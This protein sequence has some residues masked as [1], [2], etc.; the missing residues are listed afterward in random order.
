MHTYEL[1]P[2][3]LQADLGD[4]DPFLCSDMDQATAEKVQLSRSF[5]KKFMDVKGE[6]ADD[7]ALSEFFHNNERCKHYRFDSDCSF[8][9]MVREEVKSL[10]DDMFHCGPDLTMTPSVIYGGIGVGPGASIG[11]DAF[12]FYTKT[13]ASTLSGTSEELYRHYRYAIA[14][15]PTWLAGEKSRLAKFGNALVA[16][17]RLSTVPK[18]VDKSRTICTEPVLNMFLQKGIGAFFERLLIKHFGINLSTQPELNK[19]LAR[20]GS[21]DGSFGTI[22]LSCASDSISLGLV[23][24]LFPAY[25]VDWLKVARS[26]VTTIPGGAR[27]ELYMV[28]S[29]GNAFTFPLQ[30]LIFASIVRACYRT[31]G[32]NLLKARGSP[33]NFGVFGDDIVVLKE[34]FHF[35]VK[36]LNS[37]GFTVNEDKS[38]NSGLFRESCGGDYFRGHDVRG[39]YIKSLLTRAD[40]YSAVNRLVRWSARSG[41]YLWST[42]RNLRGQVD[43]LPVPHFVGDAE[44]IKTPYPADSLSFSAKTGMYKYYVLVPVIRTLRIPRS[45]EDTVH[46]RKGR[47]RIKFFYNPDGLVVSAVGG[48]LRDESITFRQIESKRF[49]VRKRFSSSWRINAAD[50]TDRESRWNAA[51]EALLAE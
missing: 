18:T 9:H 23:E 40:V 20:I 36:C 28:S 3:W 35:V 46:F 22:D 45:P 38:F 26:P 39:V 48:F 24:D 37:F 16:G 13:F 31:L 2:E 51:F 50:R 6:S 43:Y 42:V 27:L 12:D 25:V 30:T 14:S 4:L 47:R 19:S 17:S 34:A 1:K 49:K 5:M 41:V 7:A 11:V 32:I 10:L 15:N 21:V 8:V 44:G 33:G 29:M